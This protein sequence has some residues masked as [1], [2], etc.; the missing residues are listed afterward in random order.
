MSRSLRV[1]NAWDDDE[2]D[3]STRSSAPAS[4]TTTPPAILSPASRP[5]LLSRNSSPTVPAS[6]LPS[7][8]R[9][10]L[11]ILSPQHQ[12]KTFYAPELKILKRALPSPAEEAAQAASAQ[13]G[14]KGST[15]E[16]REKE[17]KEKERRY[18]EARN[19]IFNSG[20]EQS[21]G[22]KR[23][24]RGKAGS[25]THSGNS[26]PAPSPAR[27]PRSMTV[28]KEKSFQSS[29]RV[30]ASPAESSS[31]KPPQPQIK[32]TGTITGFSLNSGS[33][34]SAPVKKKIPTPAD[35]W[36][37]RQVALDGKML[38]SQAM[39][40]GFGSADPYQGLDAYN[41]REYVGLGEDAES[42][43]EIAEKNEVAAEG[44]D[45]DEFRRA[46]WD[47]SQGLLEEK[48]AG[49]EIGGGSGERRRDGREGEKE[50]KEEPMRPVREPKGPEVGAGRG[51]RGRGNGRRAV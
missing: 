42:S 39:K 32:S 17:R 41:G 34:T 40:Y 6:A 14:K 44:M 20:K 46:P 22:G 25:A 50:R 51:F 15:K 11:E 33:F 38:E 23:S 10:Q 45:W 18:Q 35:D 3:P 48:M 16:E 49:M 9:P 26:S 43:W 13:A 31:P 19:K 30:A 27:T 21:G 24:G 29:P 37:L 5:T 47:P 2:W 4:S 28:E 1:P 7:T 36:K 8:S 12:P